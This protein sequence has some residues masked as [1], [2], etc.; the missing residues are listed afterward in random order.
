MIRCHDFNYGVE[1]Y[2]QNFLDNEYPL[3]QQCPNSE[4]CRPLAKSV[5]LQKVSLGQP[6]KR[7]H[8]AV[9]QDHVE[10]DDFYLA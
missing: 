10:D 6:Q 1:T 8:N 2:S 9:A 3:P 4:Y 5:I 7:Y